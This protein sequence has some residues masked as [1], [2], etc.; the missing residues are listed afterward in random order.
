MGLS[1]VASAGW[2]KVYLASSV[3]P[4]FMAK[5]DRFGIARDCLTIDRKGR[6]ANRPSRSN[7]G[8][9]ATLDYRC[10]DTWTTLRQSRDR[11]RSQDLYS[12][13]GNRGSR[14]ESNRND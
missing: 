6:L 3:I 1:P 10:C 12:W 5:L 7:G 2:T 9:Y 4:R 11:A 8:N 13:Y 14:S